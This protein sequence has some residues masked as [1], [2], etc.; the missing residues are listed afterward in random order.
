MFSSFMEFCQKS[1][2]DK[3]SAA[4]LSG[5]L[6]AFALPLAEISTHWQHWKGGGIGGCD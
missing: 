3:N 4:D 2:S 1:K 5:V 6:E